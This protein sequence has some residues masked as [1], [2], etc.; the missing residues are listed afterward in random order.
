MLLCLQVVPQSI[1]YSMEMFNYE[2]SSELYKL[3]LLKMLH[4][5]VL[6]FLFC[7]I[8]MVSSV[9]KEGIKDL[10]ERIHSA[11][12]NA[13]DPDTHEHVIGMQVINMTYSQV[14]VHTVP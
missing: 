11:A 5:I 7:S 2:C 9:T 8:C 1:F 4:T 14:H 12:L 3:V 6:C 10:Q 13:K